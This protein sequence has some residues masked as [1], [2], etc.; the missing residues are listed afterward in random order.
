MRY[1]CLVYFAEEAMEALSDAE[2]ADL[3]RQ[4]REGDAQLAASGRFVTA[5]RSTG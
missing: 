3:A 4:C 5:S 1:L 2:Y